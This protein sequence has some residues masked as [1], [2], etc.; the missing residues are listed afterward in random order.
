MEVGSIIEH[1]Q[2]ALPVIMVLLCAILVFTF[3]FKKAEQPPFAQL[4]GHIDVDKKVASKK[5]AK[6]KE[7]VSKIILISHNTSFWIIHLINIFSHMG[8]I[9]YRQ[10]SHFSSIL[11]IHSSFLVF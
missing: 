1:S 7:K 5:R 3:G 8:L 10:N 4:S 9:C 6:A 2:Y 11:L